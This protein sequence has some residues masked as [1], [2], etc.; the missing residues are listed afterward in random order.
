[1][2]KITLLICAAALCAMNLL[3]Q[4]PTDSK[5]VGCGGNAQLTA[6]PIDG[7]HFVKW[8]NGFT[9]ITYIHFTYIQIQ[10]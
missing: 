7:Y 4:S 2:K 1:M 10:W 8:T 5:K 9:Y 3:A 6:T